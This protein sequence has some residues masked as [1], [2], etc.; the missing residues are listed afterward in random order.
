MPVLV[1]VTQVES[2]KGT[3]TILVVALVDGLGVVVQLMAVAF[4]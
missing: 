3:V 1:P 4:W 2:D